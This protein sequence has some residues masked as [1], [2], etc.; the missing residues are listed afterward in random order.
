[1]S[2]FNY[3]SHSHS[4]CAFSNFKFRILQF[5][6]ANLA[7]AFRSEF[8]ISNLFCFPLLRVAKSPI[9]VPHLSWI[10]SDRLRLSAPASS[11]QFANNIGF[12]L[13]PYQ[14]H[15]HSALQFM[16]CSIHEMI[17]RIDCAKIYV[18]YDLP[19]L[20]FSFFPINC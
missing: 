10:S 14:L 18:A 4:H 5:I 7:L 11:C 6:L 13:S 20:R 19:S 17:L 8:H 2:N 9:S 16:I 3:I 12:C 15:S 1:M